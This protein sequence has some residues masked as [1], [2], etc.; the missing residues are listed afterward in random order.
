MNNPNPQTLAGE[1]FPRKRLSE[2]DEQANGFSM[3]PG[4]ST[5][6]GQDFVP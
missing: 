4:F 5:G 3:S 6:S 1:A 2:A